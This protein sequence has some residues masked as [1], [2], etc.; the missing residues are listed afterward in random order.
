MEMTRTYSRPPDLLYPMMVIAAIAVIVFSI[1]GIA[2]MAGWMPRAMIG[3]HTATAADTNATTL[4]SESVEVPRAGVVFHCAEC[5]VI[6]SVREIERRGSLW[7]VPVAAMSEGPAA[8]TT[9]L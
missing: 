6:E 5:G 8:E 7:A 1:L 4:P 9:G 3:S 2:S